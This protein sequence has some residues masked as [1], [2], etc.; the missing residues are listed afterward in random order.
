[1]SEDCGSNGSC[2]K[3]GPRRS[4]IAKGHSRQLSW[5]KETE[6]PYWVLQGCSSFAQSSLRLPSTTQQP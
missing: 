4:F 6:T 1:M 2:N 3:Q 5:Y